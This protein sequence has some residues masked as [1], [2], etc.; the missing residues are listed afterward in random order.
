MTD[1]NASHWQTAK[2]NLAEIL[3]SEFIERCL[4]RKL[5][6][7]DV[8]ALLNGRSD[9]E[10]LRIIRGLDILG[11]LPFALDMISAE[12]W[13]RISK[14]REASE[15]RVAAAARAAIAYLSGRQD[16]DRFILLLQILR[17]EFDS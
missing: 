17:E 13:A 8:S 15:L 7:H 5:N 4:T 2:G 3:G 12:S 14:R 16:L 11:V 6:D 10:R 9:E 1:Q